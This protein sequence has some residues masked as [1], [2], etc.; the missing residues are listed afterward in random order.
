M[1]PNVLIPEPSD[2]A[3]VLEGM[4]AAAIA[5][6]MY[7]VP[8]VAIEAV[9]APVSETDP[10]RYGVVATVKVVEVDG[11]K[12]PQVFLI[13]VG[14]IP[15]AVDEDSEER[16][17]ITWQAAERE[18][19]AFAPATHKALRQKYYPDERLVELGEQLA[20]ANFATEDELV[21][22]LAEYIRTREGA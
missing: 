8:R 22:A 20:K 2:E 9:F 5:L 11:Q 21:D 12:A 18:F 10:Q 7:G 16:L 1:N 6:T 14:P 13:N 19:A 4:H 3:H 15:G 17:A